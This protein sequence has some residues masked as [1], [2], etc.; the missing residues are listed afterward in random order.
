M[1]TSGAPDFMPTGGNQM[2]GSGMP[3]ALPAPEGGIRPVFPQFN[4]A[5]FDWKQ[6]AKE[7]EEQIRKRKLN[8]SDFGVMK[9]GTQVSP[10]FSWRGYAKSICTRLQASTDPDLP[11]A[12]GCPPLDWRGWNM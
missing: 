6:R 1:S 12:C 10:E 7:I 11:V 3:F 9:P 8:P 5:H 2:P 4:V